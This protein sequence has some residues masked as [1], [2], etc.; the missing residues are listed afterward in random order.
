MLDYVSDREEE[1][2]I[3][4]WCKEQAP[5]I[6]E[7]ISELEAH[8]DI[9]KKNGEVHKGKRNIRLKLIR[10]LRKELKEMREFYIKRRDPPNGWENGR[11]KMK[12]K[13]HEA[14]KHL[15]KR[16]DNNMDERLQHTQEE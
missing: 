11:Y 2:A 9:I 16:D 14:R 10:D 6:K 13:I 8:V 3:L 12:G 15:R 7:L 4:E 5:F 1:E